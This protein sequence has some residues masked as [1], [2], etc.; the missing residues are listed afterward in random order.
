MRRRPPPHP[1]VPPLATRSTPFIVLNIIVRRRYHTLSFCCAI[2]VTQTINYSTKPPIFTRQRYSFD[3]NDQQPPL[4]RTVPPAWSFFLARV[5]WI[6]FEPGTV[7]CN[8]C[9][10]HQFVK[11]VATVPTFGTVD[12]ILPSSFEDEIL[13]LPLRYPRS[14]L[15]I[16]VFGELGEIPSVLL[17]WLS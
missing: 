15:T 1:T 2:A 6:I 16:F 5:A 14:A 17:C 12:E 13:L 4:V 10:I 11:G 9:V 7:D 3:N 8:P